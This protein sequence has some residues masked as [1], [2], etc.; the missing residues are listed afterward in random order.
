MFKVG[1]KQPKFKLEYIIKFWLP[2]LVWAFVIFS[3]SSHPVAPSSAIYW[4]DFLIKKTAHVIEYAILTI[5]LYRALKKSEI[6]VKKA[7]TYS[8]IFTIFYGLTDELH[9]S[10]TPGRTPRLR[11]VGIDTLGSLFSICF[12]WY[13]LPKCPKS[14]IILFQKL[15]IL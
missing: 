8:I 4:K 2:F 12:I 9:Q 11:D 10:L 15:E 3:F 13:L 5:L 1:Q 6:N 7:G 14:L